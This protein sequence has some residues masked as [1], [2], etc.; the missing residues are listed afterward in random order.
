MNVDVVVLIVGTL[1][2]MMLNRPVSFYERDDAAADR[3]FNPDRDPRIRL[4]V[5]WIGMLLPV[6]V[7]TGR[8]AQLQL[9][10]REDFAA[11]FSLTTETL[12]DIPA[13]D[14][15]ILAADGSILAGDAETYDLAV[16]YPALKNPPDEKWVADQSRM[17]LSKTDRKDQAKVEE[18]KAKILAERE[19]AWQ[20]IA[21]LTDRSLDEI[22]EAREREQQRVERIK[23]SVYRRQ[24]QRSEAAAEKQ[25]QSEEK[26]PSVVYSIWD[27]VQQALSEPPERDRGP[28]PVQE[29]FEYHTVISGIDAETRAEIEAHPERYPYTQIIVHRRRH[30]PAGEL[31]SHVIGIRKPL[32]DEQL[33]KRK[34]RFPDGDPQ[35]YRLGDP[36]G[37]SGLELSYDSL[38]KGVRGQRALVKNRRGEI[39]ETRVVRLPQHGRDLVLTLDAD[40]QRRAEQLLDEALAKVTIKGTVDPE[41][42]QGQFR[43]PTCPQGGALVALDVQTGAILAAAAAPRFDLNLLITPD[44]A[45]WDEVKSDP[46][47]PFLS[48]VTQMALPPGSVFKIVSAV[49]A[50]ESGKMP[51]LSQFHCQGFLDRPDRNRCLPFRH[52]GVG[53]GDVSLADALCRSCNVYF[54]TAARRMGPRS[55]VDWARRFG[56]GQPTG[57]DL[58]SESAGRL[59]V[60]DAPLGVGEVQEKWKP[61]TTLDLSIGQ[62]SLMMTPLQMARIMAAIANDGHLVTPH[63]AAD[64]G[65]ASMDET[66][67]LRS[68]IPASQAQPIE[69]LR[70]ETLGYVR[71]GLTMVV[72]HPRGTA[73]KTVRM[74]E[75]TIAGKT[76]TAETSGV[77][78]AWFA[79]Y[80]PAEQ[81][82]IAFV[83]V[84]QNGGSGGAVAGPVAHDFLKMLV[85]LGLVTK[86]SSLLSDR[87]AS[88]ISSEH[89]VD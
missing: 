59:P 77:D 42:S 2:H 53:H 51:P 30:Y 64:S 12:E 80:A 73:Y 21:E 36:C 81:P 6:L 49:A 29:E 45:Q 41:T 46:R 27:Q 58:P 48:R 37:L 1:E 23:E 70:R 16:Y 15:R 76:G 57:I 55:L 25:P 43:D 63:F 38:L 17:R 18:Q 67:Y 72:H 52:S 35:D 40:V 5:L 69:G 10:L 34:E 33:A 31:A 54:Y 68:A 50:I 61:G 26:S 3:G 87:S 7:V 62:S 47:S 20:K 79:G 86:P 84:L 24:L 83:V 14:G 22:N 71:E 66:S 9:S 74:K 32:T 75:I 89:S 8:V 78:H 44:A 88:R 28:Q 19:V 82:R 39:V 4:V 56:V 60:P 65:P 13:R 11:A 85:E